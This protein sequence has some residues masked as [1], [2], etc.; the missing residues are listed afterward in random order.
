MMPTKS[1]DLSHQLL[2]S[3]LARFGLFYALQDLCEK[4]SN[5][6]MHFKYSSSINQNEI[7]R[8]IWNENVFYDWVVKQYM[9]HSEASKAKLTERQSIN[10]NRGRQRQWI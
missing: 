3:L 1:S 2:P 7:P 8:R 5:A 10:R 4:N 6:N 9:K